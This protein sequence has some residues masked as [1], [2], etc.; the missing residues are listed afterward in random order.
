MRILVTGVAG[1]IG[2]GLGRILRRWNFFQELHGV[3]ASQDHAGSRFFDLV[4]V[5]PHAEA[6]NYIQWISRYLESHKIDV[7]VPTSEA[8]IRAVTANLGVLNSSS[9]VLVNDL[10]LVE[11][12]LDKAKTLNFLDESGIIVPK[13]GVTGKA[14]LPR[15]YPVIVKPRTGQGGKGLRLALSQKDLRACES[16]QVWQEYL[17]PDDQEYSCAVFVTKN[18]ETR[19]LILRRTLVGGSTGRAIVVKNQLIEEY[20]QLIV[21][22]FGVAGAYN[23]QLRLTSEGP[24]L[25]EINPRLS[26]TV[27]FRDKI[28]FQDFR[29]WV[30][31]R[32]G[33]ELPPHVEAIA[34]TKFFRGNE[35][36]IFSPDGAGGQ[37]SA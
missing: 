17:E 4:S 29:W 24:K 1:D 36:Y 31:D 30:L 23:I 14:P 5:A 13:H 3:D 37:H 2:I 6:P 33:H 27:V 19:T 18:F 8:E 25:F 16:N 34:G 32:L 22:T 26:S 35:E 7:F 11:K 10:A 9:S 20:L 12:C 28:G 21:T 15:R